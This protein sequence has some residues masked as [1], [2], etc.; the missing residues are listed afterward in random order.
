MRARTTTRRQFLGS[1]AALAAA[2]PLVSGFAAPL[3]GSDYRALVC[4]F[5]YGGNDGNN[6]VV[7]LDST[8]YAAYAKARGNPGAGGLALAQSSLA[9]LNGSSLGLHGALAPL[10]EVWN[11]GHLA[12]QANV[13]TLVRPLSKLEF[14][15]GGAA[16]PGNLFS[17]SDQQSQWQQGGSGLA[18]TTGWAGRIADLQTQAAVPVAISFSGN[19]VF[20]NGASTDG[21]ALSSNGG[22]AVKG[23]GGNP[24]RNPL[25]SLYTSLLQLP[26]AN[27]QQ[28][29]TAAVLNQ[30]LRAS[31]LLNKA[32]SASSSVRGCTRSCRSCG[33]PSAWCAAFAP[34]APARSRPGRQPSASRLT[35]TCVAGASF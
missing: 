14:G 12:V 24:A 27:A 29:A 21:L 28:R 25:Y 9:P 10:A 26:Y 11:Q 7:P 22:F 4:I 19:S 18:Q 32:L 31:E 34:W 6:M 5:L 8:G 23:F 17:H 16:V 30:G 2:G 13:G 35:G 15:A 33:A 1:A 3:L 20:I